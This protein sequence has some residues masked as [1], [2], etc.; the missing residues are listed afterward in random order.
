MLLFS[1]SVMSDRLWPYGL[2]HT[3]ISCPSQSPG[4]CSNSFPLNRWYHPTV[5]SSITCF[6]SCLQ[7]LPALRVFSSEL[8][9]SIRW[10][11]SGPS[12]SVLPMNIQDFRIDWFDHLMVQGTLKSILQY[13]SPK[14]SVLRHS[15]FFNELSHPY[16]TTG[17]TIALTVKRITGRKARDLQ[18][19]EIDCK[20]SDIFYLS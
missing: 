1:H 5:S 3:R 6:S 11:N 17:K 13:H 12:I 10:P 8:A 18:I 15:A 19:K 20:V 9:L 16:M 14:A 4:A 2:Q 7:S